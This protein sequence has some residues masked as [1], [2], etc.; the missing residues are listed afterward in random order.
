MVAIFPFAHSPFARA[1]LR[2]D[3]MASVY[4]GAGDGRYGTVAVKGQIEFGMQYNYKQSALEI[5][6][7]QCKE[8]AAVDA[9]RN[10]SDP[11]VKVSGCYPVKA[12]ENVIY[13]AGRSRPP[14]SNG[15]FWPSINNANP[16]AIVLAGI[17]AA[18]QIKKWQAQNKGEKAHAQ[19]DIRRNAQVL[20]AA[21]QCGNENAV[22]VCLA[23]G[24]VWP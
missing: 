16:C 12:S 2:S 4:S 22:G 17:S 23:L 3:S 9:K 21:E 5:H 6:V 8:L 11:Y 1:Q 14:P 18:G 7:T 15:P 10:R 19:S 24:H 13:G 20:F